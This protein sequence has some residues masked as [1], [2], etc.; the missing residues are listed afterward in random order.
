MAFQDVRS[1]N[2]EERACLDETLVSQPYGYWIPRDHRP[3]RAV[4]SKRRRNSRVHVG[5][6][7][8]L[9]RSPLDSS[10]ALMLAE[11]KI[12]SHGQMYGYRPSIQA[13][14]LVLPLAQCI[15]CRFL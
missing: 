5:N 13:R 3:S 1:L 6:G 11:A 7:L 8:L 4:N 10:P 9:L 14:R 2:S 12:Y 15:H